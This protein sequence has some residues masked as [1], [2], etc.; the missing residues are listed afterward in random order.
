MGLNT[1]RLPFLLL[2][3]VVVLAMGCVKEIDLGDKSRRFFYFVDGGIILNTLEQTVIVGITKGDSVNYTPVFDASVSVIDLTTN[4]EVNYRL[5]GDGVYCGDLLGQA[6]HLYQ[7]VVDI[8]T[9]GTFTSVADSISSPTHNISAKVGLDTRV[10]QNGIVQ[11]RKSAVA[12]VDIETNNIQSNEV[13]LMRD[14]LEWSY[15]DLSTG[16]FDPA[17]ICYFKEDNSAQVWKL[18]DLGL[19]QPGGTLSVKTTSYEIDHRFAESSV[20]NIT[21]TRVSSNAATYFR[22]INSTLSQANT[23][24]S[25]RPLPTAGNMRTSS[26]FTMLGYF[27]AQEV[28]KLYPSGSE[29]EVKRLSGVMLC[30]RFTQPRGFRCDECLNSPG[31]SDLKP[32]YWP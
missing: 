26:S 29:S 2:A 10:D 22:E 18:I 27:G 5:C 3:A 15:T 13:I 31:S 16:P 9:V 11:E 20:I 17:R 1:I 6:G 7:L 21:L 30:R 23:F 8:P 14:Q 4:T 32:P 19:I 28:I 24:F 25:E 12:Y